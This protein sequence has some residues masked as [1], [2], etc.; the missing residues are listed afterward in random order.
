MGTQ[1]MGKEYTLYQ[2]LLD[3]KKSNRMA[4][5]GHVF[6]TNNQ[7]YLYDTGTGKVL[8]LNDI[9]YAFFDALL[10]PNN[11][12]ATVEK[13]VDHMTE[14]TFKEI[15]STIDAEHLMARPK[16]VKMVPASAE[17]IDSQKLH[18]LI[19]EVTEKCNFRCK[20]CIYSESY[21]GNR[22]FGNRNMS[23]ETAKKALDFAFEHSGD[24]LTI[25][26]YGG[27]P[28][29][30]LDLIKRCVE[31]VESHKKQRRIHYALTTNLSLIKAETAEY[32]ASIKNLSILASMDGPEAIHNA[33]RVYANDKPTFKDAFS[34]LQA[35]L[36]AFKGT[37]NRVAINAVLTPS[38]DFAKL[39]ALNDFFSNIANLPQASQILITYPSAGTF[40]PCVDYYN[41]IIARNP[42][43]KVGGI[44]NP[45]LKWQ[46]AMAKKKGL[47]ENM[48][49]AYYAGM[50]QYLV[51]AHQR[52][53]SDEPFNKENL[54][55]CCKIGQRR[56]YVTVDGNFKACERIGNSPVLGD[57]DNGYNVESIN[58]NYLLDYEKKS[59]PMC[60]S[61]WA[62][63][64]CTVCYAGCCDEHG[65]NIEMKA[66]KCYG[67]RQNIEA[68]LSVYHEML[69][70]DPEKL[71]FLKNITTV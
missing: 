52:P 29:I 8:R 13:V 59:L 58:Q 63:N 5:C 3:L 12:V 54:N 30:N 20:Y 40:E 38:Y 46:K 66:N 10:A 26:F 35:L 53:I 43:Y 28:L 62:Y 9:S 57:V 19:L 48:K 67:A 31:Y 60:D 21:D 41:D 51:M 22:D 45:L 49:N 50:L 55:G 42:Q 68:A 1:D 27:E 7:S 44:V 14:S 23:W 39:D 34:G 65:L 16:L 61:C 70:E 47:S 32:L 56:L 2:H 33:T 6:S 15:M 17:S 24:D 64:L 36:H 37:Q 4:R 69:E 71:D 25:S 11:S 18:Q